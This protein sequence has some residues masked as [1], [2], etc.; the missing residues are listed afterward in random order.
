MGSEVLSPK[1]YKLYYHPSSNKQYKQ[2]VVFVHHM[3]GNHKT[4]W[5]H[6]RYLNDKGFDCVSFDLVMGSDLNKY[7]PHHLLKY[8]YKGVFYIWTRQ[9]R[10]ILDEVDGDKIVYAFSGP[11]LSALWASHGRNDVIKVIVDGGPFHKVYEN[12]R[13][14]FYH[15]LG[16]KNPILNKICAFL[17]KTIWG[18][19][20]LKKLH[21]ILNKWAIHVP[22][23]SIRGEQD[24]IVDI[25][26]IDDVFSPHSNL[27]L[28][29]LELPHG[30]HLDGMK[31]FPE[32][33]CKAMLPFIKKNL[34]TLQ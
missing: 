26:T 16:I 20:P 33:Y 3:W 2:T 22:I 34:Q 7:R 4:T 5:R 18:Y 24:N 25:H 17:G 30:R 11:S 13:N 14:F 21:R 9:I 28:T 15:E 12:S 1:G 23:L 29:V 10:D 8:F 31:S 27:N 32:V 19:K 6:Y